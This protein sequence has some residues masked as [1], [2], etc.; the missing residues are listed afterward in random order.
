VFLGH[1]AVGLAAKRA[2]PR[3]PVTALLFAA[4]FLDVLWPIFLWLGVEQVR[5]DP[6]NTAF[7][8]LDFVSYPYSHSLVMA[9]AWSVLF[10]VSYRGLT[11]DRAG[12]VWI[13]ICV[14][15]HWVLDALTHRADLP[16]V[17]WGGP[18][19]GLGLWNS[20]TTTAATE[21]VMTIAGLLLYLSATRAR[22]WMGSLSLWSLVGVLAF[23]YMGTVR[24]DVPPSV[25]AIKFMMTLLIVV[26][27]AWFIWIDRTR[28]SR[29]PG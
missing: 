20:V 7:T 10:A 13:G 18:K 24:G 14:L 27:L 1:F 5:I 22:G 6:G 17:P 23:F 8:P 3:V 28:E 15:S 26:M 21:I 9:L 25:E 4:M 29:I 11:R 2:A 19:V 16:L 12:A